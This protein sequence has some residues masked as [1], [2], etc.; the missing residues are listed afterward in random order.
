MRQ[1]NNAGIPLPQGHGKLLHLGSRDKGLDPCA[2]RKIDRIKGG[3][4]R[5]SPL[6]F[7]SQLSDGAAPALPLV[8]FFQSPPQGSSGGILLHGIHGRAHGETGLIH[9]VLAGFSGAHTKGGKIFFG[10]EL[11]EQPARL[12]LIPLGRA[13]TVVRHAPVNQGFVAGLPVLLLRNPLQ[14]PHA[15]Q[16]IHLALFRLLRVPEGIVAAGGLRQPGNDGGLGKGDVGGVFAKIRPCR[17]LDAVGMLPQIDIIEVGQQDLILG[18][19]VFQLVGQNGLFHL[20]GIAALRGQ[21]QLLDDLLRD[22]AAALPLGTAGNIDKGRAG[23]GHGIHAAVTVEVVVLG[24]EKGQRQILGHVFQ[25]DDEAL[26]MIERAQNGTVTGKNGGRLRRMIVLKPR[27]IG[28]IARCPE[29]QHG[30]DSG[31]GNAA[32]NTQTSHPDEV[33]FPC[34]VLHHGSPIPFF[35]CA[36]KGRTADP[37]PETH[38]GKK[39]PA[40]KRRNKKRRK[41]QSFRLFWTLQKCVGD[42]TQPVGLGRPAILQAPLPGPEG[43]SSY[44]SFSL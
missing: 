36:V 12:L 31:T 42:Y 19:R 10:K 23:D 21:Q 18:Q 8:Q 40:E 38:A 29:K 41:E 43:K 30:D 27:Q 34:D 13:G 33:F 39:P 9:R 11:H 17:G 24:G 25:R 15:P 1:R 6:L 4:L 20:A 16:H 5:K 26:F 7:R 28:Q 14:R 22:G 35:P 3:L 37:P 32:H 44:T 2:A